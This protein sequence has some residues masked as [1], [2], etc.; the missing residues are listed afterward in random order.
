[1]NRKF[2]LFAVA[3]LI[4]AALHAAAV[5]DPAPVFSLN[6]DHGD[7]I[8]LSDLKG[9]V[10]FVN[11]WASW[12]GPCAQELPKLSELA[13]EY[14]KENF[15]LLA[16]NVDAD[17][18]LAHKFLRTLPLPPSPMAI[19]WDSD[20]KT[21]S[22]YDPQT[23]PSSYIVDS[24]GIIRFIHSGYTSSDTAKWRQEIESILVKKA[25]AETPAP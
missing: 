6:N 4:G 5:K 9:R 25:P 16:V 13:E 14:K 3:M 1:M 11:F 10:V 21:V 18:V 15:A 17:A 20:S 12:C 8:S 19:I 7:K 23:M 22:A 24:Q 2:V